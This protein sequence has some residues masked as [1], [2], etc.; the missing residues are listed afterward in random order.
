MKLGL[1]FGYQHRNPQ[2]LIMAA[3]AAE[4]LGYDSIWTSE[5]YGYDAVTPLLWMAA[6]TKR[7]KVGTAIMQMAARTPAM[8]AMTAA[9]A[10]FLTEGRF[11]LG[12]GVSGPQV[13][14]GW[15]GQ[16]FGKP[17]QRTREYVSIVRTILKRE[18]PLEHHGSHYDIPLQGGSGLGKPLKLIQRPLR[19]HIPIYLAAIGPKNVSLAAEIADG[20][21]PIFFSPKRIDVFRSSLKE[22]IERAGEGR[23]AEDLSIAPTVHVVL[24]PDIEA[25]R[26]YVKKQVALYVGGMGAPSK[27]FYNRL[28]RRYGYEDAAQRIQEL[29]LS[30]RKEESAAAVPDELIDEMAL[31]GPSERIAELASSWRESGVTE[32]L[33]APNGPEALQLIPRL[34]L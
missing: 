3:Q 15:H 12:L 18:S 2:E 26:F 9:T 20:W 28:M 5:A 25:C 4:Q 16:L 10:D 17:L 34:L 14:E 24:G 6:H 13:V 32:V 11:M 21:L 29:F 8:T 30:G 31:C 19:S 33:I 22:G 7:L 23:K 1:N 27:N